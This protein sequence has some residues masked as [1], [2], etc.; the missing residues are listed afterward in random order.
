MLNAAASVVI[1]VVSV[2]RYCH[3]AHNF[4]LLS[5][6]P[7]PPLSTLTLLASD[8]HEKLMPVSIWLDL[9]CYRSI[10]NCSSACSRGLALVGSVAFIVR[11][12]G[13]DM[14][15]VEVLQSRVNSLLADTE[16][17]SI[18]SAVI[19][20]WI[21]LN[22]P[23]ASL[24]SIRRQVI[25]SSWNSFISSCPLPAW[26]TELANKWLPKCSCKL[27]LCVCVF[28]WLENWW[29]VPGTYAYVLNILW[30]GVWQ[31]T[32]WNGLNDCQWHGAST[33]LLKTFNDYYSSA[34]SL[35]RQI[36]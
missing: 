3:M 5:E 25:K 17:A 16:V 35:N 12:V 33:D 8:G 10:L 26:P 18:F 28:L 11:G 27:F 24:S 20:L 30:Q 19:A 34:A 4:S 6:L 21:Y 7:S 1:F 14:G 36:I 2:G 29:M 13:V 31:V 9:K 15:G 23:K 32:R 22:I